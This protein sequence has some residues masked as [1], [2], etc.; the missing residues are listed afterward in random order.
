MD[1]AW[2]RRHSKFKEPNSQKLRKSQNEKK[3]STE[4]GF[5]DLDRDSFILEDRRKSP[6]REVVIEALS[7]SLSLHPK[8]FI[9]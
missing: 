6:S 1:I 7:L 5:A 9:F 4:Y 8:Y 2:R 3:N